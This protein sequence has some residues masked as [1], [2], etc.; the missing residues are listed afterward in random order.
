MFDGERGEMGTIGWGT[1]TNLFRSYK[2]Q[3]PNIKKHTLIDL[4]KA[5]HSKFINFSYCA[6][7][8]TIKNENAL[9]NATVNMIETYSKALKMQ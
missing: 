9:H 5:K 2:Q 6:I 1:Q 8:P 7:D 3:K 4:D